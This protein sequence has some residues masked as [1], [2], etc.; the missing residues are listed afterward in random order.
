MAAF[1]VQLQNSMNSTVQQQDVTKYLGLLFTRAW[2][3]CSYGWRLGLAVTTL[4]TL[5]KLPYVGRGSYWDGWPCPGSILGLGYLSLCDQP[6]G[7]L[8]LAIPL[9]VGE[10]NTSQRVGTPC[11][12]GVKAGMVCVWVACKT[13][14]SHCCTLAIFECFRDKGLII[15][16]CINLSVYFTLLFFSKHDMCFTR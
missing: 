9:W 13:V 14:W 5:M 12:S 10:I 8:S 4:H 6:P 16:C 1:T 3:W 2:H 7:Q 15:K 11:G